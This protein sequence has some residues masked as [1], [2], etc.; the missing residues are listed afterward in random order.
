MILCY[1]LKGR[2][3]FL[4]FPKCNVFTLTCSTLFLFTHF[5]SCVSSGG[6]QKILNLGEMVCLAH[7]ICDW[8]FGSMGRCFMGRPFQ[9]K[10]EKFF[11]VL[12]TS[13]LWGGQVFFPICCD[14]ALVWKL[15]PVYECSSSNTIFCRIYDEGLTVN[16][17][18]QK[19]FCRLVYGAQN[20]FYKKWYLVYFTAQEINLWFLCLK[21]SLWWGGIICDSH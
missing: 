5:P 1:P 13:T 16:W 3:F 6:C 19:T 18:S 4:F 14:W 20:C 11:L 9:M 15:L 10:H 21:C 2:I 8:W 17:N 12:Y 7:Q